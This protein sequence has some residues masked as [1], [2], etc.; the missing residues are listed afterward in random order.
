[1]APERVPRPT[2]AQRHRDLPTGGD[3][4]CA[5][6]AS[7]TCFNPQTVF[8]L[9]HS[10][11]RRY[12][13]FKI[14]KLIAT[15]R[16]ADDAARLFRSVRAVREP[17]PI[18]EVEPISSIVRRFAT[19]AI[20]YGSISKEIA[21]GAGIAMNRLGAKSNTGRARG[22]TGSPATRTGPAPL[23][24]QQCIRRFGVTSDTWST[25]THPDQDLAG[26][27][28]WRGRQLRAT[29]VY[30]W[31]AKRGY[32]TPGV[33]LISPPHHNIL[34]DRGHQAAHP[35]LRTP[36]EGADHVQAVSRSGRHGGRRGGQGYSDVVLISRPRRRPPGGPASSLNTPARRGSSAWPRRSRR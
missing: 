21:R 4:Q 31:I 17:V 14:H 8:K 33:G 6:R 36:P 15:S 30:P 27:E 22:P 18:D 32:S 10:R 12:D 23:G 1:V 24:D 3:Y 9:Q 5:A 16:T 26:G 11:G 20:S 28:A 2:R 25:P 29:K 13:V 19:G 35:R 7:R 34:L